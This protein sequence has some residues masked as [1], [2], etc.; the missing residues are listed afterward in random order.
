MTNG[1]MSN[2]HHHH[3]QSQDAL[4]PRLLDDSVQQ[5]NFKQIGKYL[6]LKT[7]GEGSFGKVKLA[8]HVISG[9]QVALKMINRKILSQSDMQGRIEREIEFLKLLRHPH[10]IKLYDVIKTPDEI[11]MV[12]EVAEY[13]LFDYLVSKGR[14][15]EDESRKFFHQIIAAMDYCHRHKIVHRDLKPENILLDHQLNVKITDFGLSNAMIDGDFLKTSCGSPDYAAPEVINGK[16]YAGPE[17]DVWSLGIMLYGMICGQLPF[18]DEY[19]PNLFKK[20]SSGSFIFPDFISNEVKDLL[21][22][23]LIV[24]PVKRIT[25]TEIMEHEWFKQGVDDYIL[26][27]KDLNCKDEKLIVDESI[28]MK[29]ISTIGYDRQDIFEA[30]EEYNSHEKL[31]FE[32]NEIL[33]A[34]LLLKENKALAKKLKADDFNNMNN[35]FSPSPPLS[36]NGKVNSGYTDYP[37]ENPVTDQRL[38]SRGVKNRAQKHKWN[39]GIRSK[40]YPL[41]I[42]L[43][44]YYALQ[45]LGMEW[46]KPNEIWVVRTRWKAN[47]NEYLN[48]KIQLYQLRPEKYLVDF[49]IDNLEMAQTCPVGTDVEYAYS[50]Y[51][52]LEKVNEIIRELSVNVQK[53]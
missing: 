21:S 7:L 30:I 5:L 17:V 40:S 45:R 33:E 35:F 8:Q 47:D 41:D 12:I 31:G 18:Q 50:V 2:Y 1:V 37:I 44:I 42:M 22:R 3:D 32:K 19:I 4:I 53:T 52:F 39:F 34:Y 16:L 13:V 9:K 48:M 28:I 36:P 14:F 23:M 24:N 26:P 25:I 27:F 51:P 46:L 49:K 6:I 43:E 29:L 15:S 38:L 10:I 20:I 11:V